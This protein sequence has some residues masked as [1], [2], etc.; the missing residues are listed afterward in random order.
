MTESKMDSQRQNTSILYGSPDQ[1]TFI[2][3]IPA[4]IELAQSLSGA[5]A[6]STERK[7]YSTTVKDPYPSPPEPKTDTA[8]ARVLA[9]IPDSERVFLE[10]I[11]SFVGSEYEKIRKECGL[12]GNWCYH[13]H[14]PPEEEIA[15]GASRKK[16]KLES[17][18]QDP[19]P[20]SN[21]DPPIMLSTSSVNEFSSLSDL[22]GVEVRNPALQTANIRVKK[23]SVDDVH[24]DEYT[25]PPKA[26]FVLGT[27]STPSNQQINK[28]SIIPNLA[29]T[30]KFNLILLDPPW[31][32]RSVRRSSQ[33]HTHT[34]L[35]MA[36]LVAIMQGIFL[37]HLDREN[38]KKAIVGIWTTNSAKSHQAAYSALD[39]ANL[40]VTEEWI[41]LKVTE[42][43]EPVVPL[44]GLWRKPYEVLLIGTPKTE[45]ELK[46][47]KPLKRLLVA[48][49]DMHSRKPNLKEL[50][51]MLYFPTDDGTQTYTALEAFA[52]NLTSGWYSCGN[53]VLR[54]NADQW[55]SEP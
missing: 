27:L 50:F 49:P 23:F 6:P 16:R 31:P 55:W 52:R 3:D 35:E 13:R 11:D 32:N 26:S 41:W 17:D 25:I 19:A 33:Y 5:H 48:V 40:Q 51:E 53:D 30:T 18:V 42:N 46:G 9:R 44:D 24:T 54:F 20:V 4:S 29:E 47:S 12:S 43:G 10:T 1:K 2:L 45:T 8:R 39:S 22:Q 21:M 37:A 28:I 38:D 34:Y 14:I 7:L 15:E 36:S